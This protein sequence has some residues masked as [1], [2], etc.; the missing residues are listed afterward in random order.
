METGFTT[1]KMYEAS[2]VELVATI[3]NVIGYFEGAEADW[4]P[5]YNDTDILEICLKIINE[6]KELK[7][8]DEIGKTRII[9][10]INEFYAE[11]AKDGDNK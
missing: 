3:A 6:C 5:T 4:L 11:K 2:T 8:S 10:C 1:I 7:V 9:K